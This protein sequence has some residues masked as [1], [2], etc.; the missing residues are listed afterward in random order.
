MFNPNEYA[1]DVTEEKQQAKNTYVPPPTGSN[2]VVCTGFQRRKFTSKKGQDFEKLNVFVKIAKNLRPGGKDGS[3]SEGRG[4]TLEYWMDFKLRSNAERFAALCLAAGNEEPFDPGDDRS[5]EAAICGK[6][7]GLQHELR[8]SRYKDRDGNDQQ[9]HEFKVKVAKPIT[10]KK[11][12]TFC[13]KLV[14]DP[15]FEKDYK[16]EVRDEVD[17]RNSGGSNTSNDGFYDSDDLPF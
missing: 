1:D 5:L 6:P 7:F 17:T 9:R 16:I 2:I 3:A 13:K 14:D 11:L 15:D 10:D 4:M 12:V 8:T